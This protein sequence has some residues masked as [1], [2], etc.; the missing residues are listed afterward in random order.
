[1]ALPVDSQRGT[2]ATA[3]PSRTPGQLS[4]KV[5]S[6]RIKAPPPPAPSSKLPWFLVTLL[7]SGTGYLGYELWNLKQ[8]EAARAAQATAEN[9]AANATAASQATPVAINTGSSATTATSGGVVH[10]SKGYLIA[11]R[12]ILIS[13]K[14][15]GM[16]KSLRVHSP[17]DPETKGETLIEG[18][19]VHKGDILAELET[20]DYEADMLR[21]K[22][23][24]ASSRLRF[25]MERKNLPREIERAKSELAEAITQRDFLKG[26][27]DRWN[28]L[29]KTSTVSPSDIEKAQSDFEGAGH[30]VD[31]LRRALDLITEPQEQRL[32]V[33]ES[34]VE[35]A[36]ADLSKAEW[37]L[38]N[39]VIVSPVTGTV[40]KKN[41]E[42]GNIVNPG[43]FNGSYSICDLADLADLEVELDIQE[44]DIS[45]IFVGQ[46]C[47]I[48]AEAFQEHPYDGYVSRL[49]PI[50]NRSK[51]A[52]PVRV[53]VLIPED[54]VGIHLKP[55]M[56]AIVAFYK[57]SDSEPAQA[58]TPRGAAN[59]NAATE[60]ESPGE[61]A[62]N[63]EPASEQPGEP[64]PESENR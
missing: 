19:Q 26:Q 16:V 55:E 32:A 18:M 60:P 2:E 34:E 22:A 57:K 10:E 7:A 50:A 23:S 62:T 29:S 33:A 61:V 17:R 13:P 63:A 15:G 8:A 46:K 37:R 9:A 36:M 21:A 39:T 12:Q 54:L 44:R 3:T 51:G 27:L 56:G 4:D 1:M 5:R 43:A 25:E 11:R 38:S 64:P 48:R 40:L 42:E 41:V 45:R 52:I 35:A 28:K 30:R 20:T 24:L 6:L 31:R 49:M 14:V 58:S 53:K 47:V 59:A